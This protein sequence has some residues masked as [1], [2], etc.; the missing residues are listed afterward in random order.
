MLRSFADDFSIGIE[1]LEIAAGADAPCTVSVVTGVAAYPTIS[2][3]CKRL[4]A[5]VA[6]LR[7]N[8]YEIINHFYGETITVSGLLT[9]KDIAEQL[10]GRELGDCVFVPRNALRSGEDVFLCGTSVDELSERLNVPIRP[11]KNN[12]GEFIKEMLGIE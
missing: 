5:L 6:G 4:E 2:A 11:G 12:G 10:E 1:D 8:V 9:G 7:I 3:A